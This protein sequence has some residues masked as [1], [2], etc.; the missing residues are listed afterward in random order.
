M[1][2]G[3]SDGKKPIRSQVSL[4][5]RFSRIIS[6]PKSL[7]PINQI[8]SSLETNFD[9]PPTHLRP[10]SDHH[11]AS[12][13]IPGGP[14]NTK[15][16]LHLTIPTISHQLLSL[17]C[18]GVEH[19]PLSRVHYYGSPVIIHFFSEQIQPHNGFSYKP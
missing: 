6:T 16:Q 15:Y 2:T 11:P 13:E 19:N 8:E 5:S 1:K 3:K 17:T 4:F 18:E 14:L 12:T 9:P 7:M 10:T